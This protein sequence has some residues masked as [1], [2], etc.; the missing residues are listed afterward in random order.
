[1]R[2]V[3]QAQDAVV[4]QNVQASGEERREIAGNHIPDSEKKLKQEANSTK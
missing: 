4:E 1:M 3:V 2:L